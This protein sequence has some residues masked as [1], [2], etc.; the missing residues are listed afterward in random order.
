MLI[1][2]SLMNTIEIK[3]MCDEIINKLDW[4]DSEPDNEVTQQLLSYRQSLVD[5]PNIY[6]EGTMP[7]FPVDPRIK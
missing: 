2:E 1:K 5:Y 3:Q 6:L 4:I 7:V